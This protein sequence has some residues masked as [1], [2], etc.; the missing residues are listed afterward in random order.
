M[1]DEVVTNLTCALNAHGMADNTLLII[2]S[3][4]GG[5][6]N[7]KYAGNSYPFKGDYLPLALALVSNPLA[8]TH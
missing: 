3:D 7:V 8:L 4:N 6:S 1:L 5:D 2:V